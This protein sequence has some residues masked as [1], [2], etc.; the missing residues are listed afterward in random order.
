[1]SGDPFLFAFSIEDLQAIPI[2]LRRIENH[3][4]HDV[5]PGYSVPLSSV[6]S[7]RRTLFGRRSYQKQPPALQFKVCVFNGSA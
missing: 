6:P 4:I 3:I 7:F 1:M 2:L 5:I